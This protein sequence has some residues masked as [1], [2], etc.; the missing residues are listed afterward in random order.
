MAW[1]RVLQGCELW[2]APRGVMGALSTRS[3]AGL[4]VLSGADSAHAVVLAGRTAGL[5]QHLARAGFATLS[6]LGD[7][8]TNA[9][10]LRAAA[11]LASHRGAKRV[12]FAAQ[13]SWP[14][15]AIE[16]APHLAEAVVAIDPAQVDARVDPQSLRGIPLW[17]ATGA[18]A[19]PAAR[20]LLAR[21]RH[22]R[23]LLE[24]AA[25]AELE[26][27]AADLAGALVP[28]LRDVFGR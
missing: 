28:F 5:A 15:A 27:A 7:V 8:D 18:N 16:V 23:T 21:A 10:L 3:G 20:A 24:L 22:P 2:P 11:E 26:P 14:T 1:S 19:T 17:I 6:V 9:T 13:G 12:A 25:V 4:C